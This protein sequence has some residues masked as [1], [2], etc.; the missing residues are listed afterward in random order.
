[1]QQDNE[2]GLKD[3]MKDLNRN[4]Q[5]FCGSI[6]LYYQDI[7]D[8]REISICELLIKGQSMQSVAKPLG[9]TRERV[10]QIF[11]RI[12]KKV[13]LAYQET[14]DEMAKLK[15]ENEKLKHRNFLLENELLTQQR[16][17]NVESMLRQ[18]DT[19]CRNANLLLNTPVERLPLPQ[20]VM[21][22]LEI[23]EISRF[24][25]IPLIN[26][27]RLLKVRNCGKK[28]INDLEKFLRK[29]NLCLGLTPEEIVSRMAHL[30]DE[31]VS[32][33]N[34][35]DSRRATIDKELA[36]FLAEL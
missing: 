23:L 17:E 1:M 7:L 24:S 8:E 13:N 29:F 25:E 33:N 3:D 28:T 5:Y 9:L 2:T 34:F 26:A 12:I 30:N 31:D 6:L 11:H 14:I 15:R 10:R 16:L 18:E 4:L 32:P 35:E 36:S 20:R 27:D 19:L 22:V 21:N